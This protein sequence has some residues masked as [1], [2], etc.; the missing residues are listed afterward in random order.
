[1]QEMKAD[2]FA[3]HAHIELDRNIHETEANRASPDGA[4]E[5]DFGFACG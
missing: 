1:M 4:A 2:V 3:P 5:C